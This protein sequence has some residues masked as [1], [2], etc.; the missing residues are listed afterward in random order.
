MSEA[1]T[2]LLRASVTM[3]RLLI[4]TVEPHYTLH[5]GHLLPRNYIVAVIE[6]WLLIGMELCQLKL[7]LVG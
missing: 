6:R 1:M 2:L 5:T 4:S 3:E 7:E